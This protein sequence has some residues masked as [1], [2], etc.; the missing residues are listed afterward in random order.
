MGG[1]EGEGEE[2][3]LWVLVRA[4]DI[5]AADD[6]GGELVALLVRVH[7]HLGGGFGGGIGVGRGQDARLEQV[8]VVIAHLS[9]HLVGRDVDESTNVEF[10]GALQQD[11]GAIHVG[12]GE[13]VRVAKAQVNVRL[14]GK[15][16][17]GVN[18][19]AL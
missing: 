11:V 9:V 19:E 17:D 12:M 6:D 8:V 1:D 15:M 16:D 2:R 7:Q 3:T 5:V 18:V 13:T 4:V 14:R 10:F